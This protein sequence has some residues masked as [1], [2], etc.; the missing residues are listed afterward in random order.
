MIF[1]SKLTWS[2]H[3]NNIKTRCQKDLQLMRVISS[4]RRADY[5]TLKKLYTALI[6]PKIDYGSFLYGQAAKTHLNKVDSIQK[7][8]L[9]IALGALKCTAGYK[10][11]AESDIMPLK[12]RR[13]ELL[14]NYGYRV[15]GIE[16]H[17]TQNL[18]T[19][20]HPTLHLL[21][22][23]YRMSAVERLHY[24]LKSLGINPTTI[25]KLQM[26]LKYNTKKLPV[27][28][29]LA[30]AAKADQLPQ[31]WRTYYR[32]MIEIY[33]SDRRLVFTD[34]SKQLGRCG[35]GIWSDAFLLLSRLPSA[36]SIYTAELYALYKAVAL[37]N[38]LPGNFLI[39]TDSLSVV[40]SLQSLDLNSHYLLQWISKLFFS[41]PLNKIKVEWVP[42]HMGITGN[43]KAD[44]LAK[45]SLQL[46]NV[47]PIPKSC[48][49]LKVSNGQSYRDEWQRE[50]SSLTTKLIYFKP[51]LSPT[52]YADKPRNIQL[53]LTRIRLRTTAL[54]HGHLFKGLQPK[55]CDYC[56]E[57]LT[58]QHLI[59]E[60]P[61]Y[62]D[63]RRKLTEFCSLNKVNLTITNV[64]SHTFPAELLV[65]FLTE[66]ETLKLL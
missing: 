15:G 8:A 59:I 31:Q 43:E 19:T 45:Q 32:H 12:H 46:P 42:S 4:N 25:P 29:T 27:Y 30:T 55:Q 3:I 13:E 48:R 49:E 34:G 51:K 54:T 39:L 56:Q 65:N 7:S 53:P 50:W 66:T 63:P 28:S 52:T 14:I 33:Y 23:Q 61:A 44:A 5:T 17:P 20:H 47:N 16:D 24:G 64:T 40:R 38:T 10:I 6:R 60:C 35:Y 57:R 1:D 36:C 2:H 9:K 62:E 58:L 26:Q 18:L 21:D 11:E 41:S 37:I 22:K